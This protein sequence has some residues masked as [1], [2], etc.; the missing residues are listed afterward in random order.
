MCKFGKKHFGNK[1]LDYFL[2]GQSLGGCLALHVSRKQDYRTVNKK[3]HKKYEHVLRWNGLI[4]VSPLVSISNDM[5][6]NFIVEW[7]ARHF[8]G[9]F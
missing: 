1:N 9:K 7:F 2:M 4:L 3:K 6:P 8:L 5:R